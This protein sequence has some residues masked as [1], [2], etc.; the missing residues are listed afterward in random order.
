MI[1]EWLVRIRDLLAGLGSG[2]DVTGKPRQRHTTT[3]G[4]WAA[5]FRGHSWTSE[6]SF[7]LGNASL[8][9]LAASRQLEMPCDEPSN[10]LRA[11]AL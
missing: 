1:H 11:N 3:L 9:L 5:T 10:R 6:S 2:A 8:D 4:P 7:F